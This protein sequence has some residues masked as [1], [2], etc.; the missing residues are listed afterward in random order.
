LLLAVASTAVVIWFVR[1]AVEVRYDPWRDDTSTE[2][3]A[4]RT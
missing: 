4:N 3:S 1:Y 2:P